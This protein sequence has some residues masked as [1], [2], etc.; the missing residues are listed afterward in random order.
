MRL[1]ASA[2]L[3]RVTAHPK[4][5][6]R[7]MLGWLYTSWAIIEHMAVPHPQAEPWPAATMPQIDSAQLK[8]GHTTP[9][10]AAALLL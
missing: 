3:M 7:R 4:T 1:A 9:T 8:K 5:P 6:T 2:A 10:T